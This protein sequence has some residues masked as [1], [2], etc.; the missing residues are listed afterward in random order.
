MFQK[1]KNLSEST[2]EKR[3]KIQNDIMEQN[4]FK[5]FKNLQSDSVQSGLNSK[6]FNSNVDDSEDQ[7]SKKEEAQ[8]SMNLD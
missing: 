5:V 3:N 8:A 7:A 4:I 1:Q 2:D 6:I